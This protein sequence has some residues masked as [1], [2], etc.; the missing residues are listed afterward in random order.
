[1]GYADENV[2]L[3]QW[4]IAVIVI[5]LASLLFVIIFGV[6]VVS[7]QTKFKKKNNDLK[8]CDEH[9][10]S[11]ATHDAF[12][13]SAAVWVIATPYSRLINCTPLKGLRAGC[14]TQS[15]SLRPMA[16]RDCCFSIVSIA[17]DKQVFHILSAGVDQFPP[18][19]RMDNRFH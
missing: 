12:D 8:F 11:Q 1:M 7:I 13:G 2:L 18:P 3:P 10:L 6:T 17:C 15:V 4:A 19:H 5:G 9:P 16:F 14:C